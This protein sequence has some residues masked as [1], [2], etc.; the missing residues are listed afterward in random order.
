MTCQNRKTRAQTP[1]V[2]DF[3]PQSLACILN[4]Q[5]VNGVN[6]DGAQRGNDFFKRTQSRRDASI[7]IR[8]DF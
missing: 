2:D 6:A 7:I 1:A 8:V 5:G 4:H 3:S